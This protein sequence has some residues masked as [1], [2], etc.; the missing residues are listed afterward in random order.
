MIA[1]E[2]IAELVPRDILGQISPR[3]KNHAVTNI[4]RVLR[5]KNRDLYKRIAA[6]DELDAETVAAAQEQIRTIYEESRKWHKGAHGKTS[7]DLEG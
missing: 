4:A 6:N 2:R 7:A 1:S 5:W 3:A